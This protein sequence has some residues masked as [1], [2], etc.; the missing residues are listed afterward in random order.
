[1]H[2]YKKF[3]E[4]IL[5]ISIVNMSGYFF[6]PHLQQLKL[7]LAEESFLFFVIIT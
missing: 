7:K 5:K 2:F 4:D 3:N 1:M 6:F